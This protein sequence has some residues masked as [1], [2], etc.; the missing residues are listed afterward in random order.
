MNENLTLHKWGQ[1]A[2]KCIT[3]IPQ[4][5]LSNVLEG[6][7]PKLLLRVLQNRLPRDESKIMNN[8]KKKKR[9]DNRIRE[10]VLPK[11]KKKIPVTNTNFLKLRLFL[12]KKMNLLARHKIR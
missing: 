4:L 9:S 2:Q 12:N 6:S 1:N 8:S 7:Q 5:R 3:S 11:I 10:R